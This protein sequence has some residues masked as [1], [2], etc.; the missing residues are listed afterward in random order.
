VRY[1]PVL[2][3]QKKVIGII[4]IGDLVKE[5]IADQAF[6]IQQLEHYIAS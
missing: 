6:V 3:D 1:L 5:T 4:S 2:T